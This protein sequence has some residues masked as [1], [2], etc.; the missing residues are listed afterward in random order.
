MKKACLLLCGLIGLQT[1]ALA[2]AWTVT[3][4]HCFL[5]KRYNAYA[6]VS[7][8]SYTTYANGYNSIGQY[9][10]T[11]PRAGYYSQCGVHN[12]G[13]TRP[14]SAS[15]QKNGYISDY[16]YN[17]GL[18]LT[19]SHPF[20]GYAYSLLDVGGGQTI[21]QNATGRG[22]AGSYGEYSVDADKASALNADG[23]SH[24]TVT[25]AAEVNDNGEL[26]LVGLTGSIA[27]SKNTDHYSTLEVI[28]IKESDNQ[29]DDQISQAEQRMYQGDYGTVVY[30]GAIRVSRAGIEKTG[31]FE[32]MDPTH[33]TE[34]GNS[35]SVSVDL[36]SFSAVTN[37]PV[38]LGD[39][40]HLAVILRVDGGFDISSAVIQDMPRP[41]AVITLQSGWFEPELFPNPATNGTI[42]VRAF[43]GSEK[44]P[45]IVEATDVV[46]RTTHRLHAASLQKGVNEVKDIPLAGL[47]AGT[48]FCKISVGDRVFTRKL[49][50][51]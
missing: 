14:K 51:R 7:A 12:G 42:S 46:G 10:G 35:D 45:L 48:Y 25:G 41:T 39:D 16:I 5:Q 22:R 2:D 3:R 32:N 49:V 23:W 28:V 43:A 30:A 19:G 31:V 33:G 27:I 9:V 47:A 26:R 34:I 40:E 11:A 20:W 50:V 37:L 4:G 21:T 29:T 1:A 17:G 18:F 15:C 8:L 6:Q 38:T 44:E 24:A 36:D 13:C